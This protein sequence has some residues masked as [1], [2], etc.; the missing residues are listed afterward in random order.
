[1]SALHVAF[2][3]DLLPLGQPKYTKDPAFNLR[4]HIH[5]GEAFAA[6]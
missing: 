3:I 1:M 4:K 5:G 6:L 2:E